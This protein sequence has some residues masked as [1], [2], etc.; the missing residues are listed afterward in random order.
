MSSLDLLGLIPK[1][2][3]L[4]LASLVIGGGGFAALETRYVTTS[5]FTKSYVL[6]LKREIRELRKEI[7]AERDDRRRADLEEDLAA[8]LDEL[9]VE[10][11]ADR[12]CRN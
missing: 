4:C 5:D 11:P 7:A 1:P 6:Q 9:C 8:L 12:E 10:M 3:A 2:I